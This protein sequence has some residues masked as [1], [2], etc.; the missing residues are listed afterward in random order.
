MTYWRKDTGSEELIEIAK[1]VLD[2]SEDYVDYRSYNY[3]FSH[4]KYGIKIL[5]FNSLLKQWKEQAKDIRFFDANYGYATEEYDMK[6]EEGRTGF[7][8]YHLINKV[9][10]HLNQNLR[11]KDGFSGKQQF[12]KGKDIYY[13]FKK[14]ESFQ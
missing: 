10:T 1:I 14:E 11:W 9:N 2:K 6:T 4:L 3:P 8:E 12:N 13:Y 5:G 7:Y